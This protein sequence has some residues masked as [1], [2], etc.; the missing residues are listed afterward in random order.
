MSKP[1][2]AKA[3]QQSASEGGLSKGVWYMLEPARLAV[4][5]IGKTE[6]EIGKWT[7]SLAT[8]LAKGQRG[9]NQFADDLI[10]ERDRFIQ[11][12]QR[13][14]KMR[15]KGERSPKVT[16]DEGRHYTTRQNPTIP[17]PTSLRE[18]GALTQSKSEIPSFEVFRSFGAEQ[19]YDP[20]TVRACFDY[21]MASGWIDSKGNPV[22][23]WRGKLA[24]WV[25]NQKA[26]PATPKKPEPKPA[27]SGKEFSSTLNPRVIR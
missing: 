21:F 5:L 2:S 19:G 18:G 8:S 13:C 22:E 16:S 25:A 3:R 26:I 6:P 27:E 10:D 14:G 11:E 9:V 15:G 4:H 12:R 7:I 20:D 24:S 23:S 1:K 17:D